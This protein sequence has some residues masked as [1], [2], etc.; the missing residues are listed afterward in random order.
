MY[1][2]L[3]FLTLFLGIDQKTTEISPF[4]LDKY[5][6][7]S[8]KFMQKFFVSLKQPIYPIGWKKLK[9]QRHNTEKRLTDEEFFAEL[10]K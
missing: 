4:Y 7:S 3:Y 1:T 5:N 9:E 2:C 6:Y 10:D 8:V